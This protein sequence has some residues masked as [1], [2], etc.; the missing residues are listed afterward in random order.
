MKGEFFLN[1]RVLNVKTLIRERRN[2]GIK[3]EFTTETFTE[4]IATADSANEIAPGAY[5][6]S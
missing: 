1:F 3:S 6:Q 5:C 4:T 2:D